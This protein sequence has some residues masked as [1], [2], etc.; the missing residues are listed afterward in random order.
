MKMWQRCAW[1]VLIIL[2]GLLA[3]CPAPGG[4]SDKSSSKAITSFK[5]FV[6]FVTG[7]I[8]GT[9]INVWVPD[10]TNDLTGLVATFTTTGVSVKVGP[11]RQVSGTTANNFT[12]P[13]TYIVTAED[14]TTKSYSVAVG[15]LVAK[16]YLDA[17]SVAAADVDV[18]NGNM[19][20]KASTGRVNKFPE[21]S[22]V[23]FLNGGGVAPAG[24]VYGKVYYAEGFDTASIKIYDPVDSTHID[25]GS[26]TA[27][28]YQ[29]DWSPV[30]VGEV[31]LPGNMI[32]LPG[33]GLKVGD[34]VF[35]VAKPGNT[36][37]T[38]GAYHVTVVDDA[39]H[40]GTDADIMPPDFFTYLARIRNN[41]GT[42]F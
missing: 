4:P 32:S 41:G 16:R 40:F 20:L 38:T 23:V 6:P 29:V 28:L 18:V 25:I 12:T 2:A 10:T 26:G 37:L 7:A 9:S 24:I 21:N 19:V 31:Y 36:M 34:A 39:D 15:K 11:T 14:G 5:F 13:V 22:P 30:H 27:T 35:I 42:S 3:G 1:S 8:R 33:H 17:N